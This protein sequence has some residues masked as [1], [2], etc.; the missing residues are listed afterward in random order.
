[1]FLREVSALFKFF[2]YAKDFTTL[3]HNIVFARQYVNENV[4][5]Y[6]IQLFVFHSHEYQ[7]IVL[8]GLHEI[9]P[10]FFY[11]GKFIHTTK[12]FDFDALKYQE[13]Y[14]HKY[15][16]HFESEDSPSRHYLKH[17]DWYAKKFHMSKNLKMFWV[18][19][20]WSDKYELYNKEA[21][22]HYFV[23]DIDWNLYFYYLNIEYPF[24]LHGK[25]FKFDDRRGEYY[26]YCI[27]QILARYNA[28]RYAL[29]FDTISEFSWYTPVENGYKSQ[30]VS[31]T[32]YPYSFRP[33][34]YEYK[35]T[36][37][38]SAI[39][40]VE[41]FEERFRDV[42]AQ[43]FYELADGTKV[44]LNKPDSIE[45]VALL[46][47]GSVD[48]IDR[49]FFGSWMTLY[50][51]LL[52]FGEQYDIISE[53]KYVSYIPNVLFNFETMMRDPL[54]YQIY[55]R[56]YSFFYHYKYNLGYYK[57]EELKFPGVKI[58]SVTVDK[59]ETHY[60]LVDYDVSVLLNKNY[61]FKDAQK[62]VIR[63]FIGPKFDINGHELTFSHGSQYFY[64][65][66]QFY[67]EAVAGKN[68]YNRDST[69][70]FH[71]RKDTTTYVEL[72]KSV[73]AAV[74]GEYKFP[75]DHTVN[76][77]CGFPEHLLLPRGQ[78]DGL[79]MK[80]YVI[81]SPFDTAITEYS[82]DD[83][84]KYCGMP[85]DHYAYGY[86]LDRPVNEIYFWQPNMYYGDIQIYQSVD[87]EASDYTLKYID[88]FFF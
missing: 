74:K 86:P 79:P 84:V 57:P 54:F 15:Y 32:G 70:F 29:G 53:D 82:Y 20:D 37:E 72:Y 39:N 16:S 87:F 5:V 77:Y 64:E 17:F 10:Q 66:D 34:Y 50:H 1:R 18:K 80:I 81:A 71:T 58:S 59:F 44:Y 3:Q 23:E 40:L 31:Y 76:K 8:P 24:F 22:L 69:H 68:T 61:F 45:K 85:F 63:T 46:L 4:F 48:S 38:Y 65:I 88:N 30:L 83:H 33:N 9:F 21:N 62:I 19:S 43:G 41:T 27:R 78:A 7:Y 67:Y 56:L 52:G 26:F 51:T 6:A 35:Y 2:Y 14:E 28:E 75:I 11:N 12:G 47:Q 36:G 42:I 60:D 73:L 49:K 55:Y 13:E 25:T